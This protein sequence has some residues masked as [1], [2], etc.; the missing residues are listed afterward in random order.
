L[1]WFYFLAG[2]GVFWGTLA[3]FLV[4]PAKSTGSGQIFMIALFVFLTFIQ[5]FH[6]YLGARAGYLIFREWTGK[7]IIAIDKPKFEIVLQ[8]LDWRKT[9]T[10]VVQKIKGLQIIKKPSPFTF[11]PPWRKRFYEEK[12]SLAYEEK[13]YRFG[14]WLK[15]KEAVEILSIIQKA[16]DEVRS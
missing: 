13:T 14:F 7:E 1:I 4:S 12:I 5:L 8:I 16:L 11:V 6:A 2:L 15:E 9:K 10:L 3:L